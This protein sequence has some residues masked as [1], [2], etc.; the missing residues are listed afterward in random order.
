MF[1]CLWVRLQCQAKKAVHANVAIGFYTFRTAAKDYS[2]IVFLF[3]IYIACPI[4]IGQ[5]K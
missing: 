5:Y 4:V 1:P 2:A 3:D